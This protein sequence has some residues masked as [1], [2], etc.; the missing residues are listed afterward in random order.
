MVLEESKQL[1]LY[2]ELLAMASSKSLKAKTAWAKAREYAT[3]HG[4]G[5]KEAR[6]ILAREGQQNDSADTLP[7]SEQKPS[8]PAKPKSLDLAVVEEQ[9]RQKYP[10]IIAGTLRINTDGPHQGRRTVEIACQTEGCSNR[11]EIHT[12]DAFQ[13]RLCLD[14][15]LKARKSKR[16]KS[17]KKGSEG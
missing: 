6:S 10:H 8:K 4:I 14:C 1:L 12:S 9:L 5:V 16:A 13:V 15:T 7:V 17:T 3:E 11:R 2:L